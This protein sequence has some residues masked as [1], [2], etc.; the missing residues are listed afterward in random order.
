MTGPLGGGGEGE[1]REEGRGKGGWGERK[2]EEGGRKGVLSMRGLEAEG[3]EK[4]WASGSPSTWRLHPRQHSRGPEPGRAGDRHSF[5]RESFLVCALLGRLFTS[6]RRC[7]ERVTN[8]TLSPGTKFSAPCRK[9][10]GITDRAR[11]KCDGV[12]RVMDDRGLRKPM[13]GARHEYRPH[14][15]PLTRAG[16]RGQRESIS[17]LYLILGSSLVA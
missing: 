5:P 13:T 2:R 6:C 3:A 14:P 7:L 9:G 11:G 17:E 1:G 15:D 4:E 16:E 12:Y 10:E 8:P